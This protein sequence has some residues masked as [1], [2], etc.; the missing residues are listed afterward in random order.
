MSWQRCTTLMPAGKPIASTCSKSFHLPM[1]FWETLKLKRPMTVPEEALAG[2]EISITMLR[3]VILGRK[4]A[5]NISRMTCD[6]A[7]LNSMGSTGNKSSGR[8]TRNTKQNSKKIE[9]A[10]EKNQI[11]TQRRYLHSYWSQY[12]ASNSQRPCLGVTICH[13]TLRLL[14]KK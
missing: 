11:K 10:E 6:T 12:F 3:R 13:H 1:M 8:Q 7:T 4:I 2:K 14:G 9:K 5:D